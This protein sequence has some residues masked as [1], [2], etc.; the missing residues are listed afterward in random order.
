MTSEIAAVAGLVR[1]GATVDNEAGR[2]QGWR[3]S[4]LTRRGA[5]GVQAWIPA[6]AGHGFQSIVSSDLGRARATADI[7]SEGLG[8]DVAVDPGLREQDW[9]DWSGAAIKDLHRD[10]PRTMQE[11]IRRGW[12]FRPPGG[13]S[14]RD[15]LHRALQSLERRA[16]HGRRT[17]IVT[18]EGVV[19]C[20]A[21]HLN[22]RAFLPEEPKLLEGRNRLHLLRA[23]PAPKII[24]LNIPL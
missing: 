4:P 6:L 23:G 5:A 14:R 24:E 22:G 7:L 16:V 19:K 21:Y 12:D 17:L 18:H 20:L 2:I 8:L 1:H 15:V 13:E 9:G 11:H 3:D 10:H